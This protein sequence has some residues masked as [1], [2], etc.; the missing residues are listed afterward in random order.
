M[1]L[2]PLCAAQSRIET[3]LGPLTL[4]ASARGLAL[5]W[6]DGQA[7]RSAA[8]DA[9]LQPGHPHLAQAAREFAEYF[10]G[11][12]RDFTVP[13]DPQGTDFQQ[14]VWQALR[15]IPMGRLS[16]YGEIARQLGRPEAARAVG[17][18][19]G[20]NPVS[21]AVPCHRVVGRDGSLTGYA[22]G[23]PRKATLLRL[24]GALAP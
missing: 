16:T 15:G 13:L 20:R 21:I 9:P 11:T 5:A 24:E 19:I 22:G 23:L 18:A 10:A 17:A 4:A 2:A 1:K 8:V 7:H 3:P 14:R 6:F 12:R